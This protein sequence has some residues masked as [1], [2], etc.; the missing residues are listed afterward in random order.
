MPFSSTIPSPYDP[1]VNHSAPALPA[2]ILLAQIPAIDVNKHRRRYCR[3][4]DIKKCEKNIIRYVKICTKY[5]TVNGVKQ[6][7]NLLVI[8]FCIYWIYLF[9]KV[10]PISQLDFYNVRIMFN[11]GLLLDFC[12]ITRLG[13][14]EFM[15][16][17]LGNFLLLRTNNRLHSNLSKFL[18]KLLIKISKTINLI[19]SNLLELIVLLW[20]SPSLR[21]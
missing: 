21:K 2:Y 5:T 4:I 17:K 1:P 11:Q 12:N 15:S 3:F 14:P 6:C 8:R 7:L 19:Q 9:N 16:S 18:C 13:I 10:L 20:L